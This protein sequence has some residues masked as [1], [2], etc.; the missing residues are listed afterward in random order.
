[1]WTCINGTGWTSW[2]I[3]YLRSGNNRMLNSF[4]S[5]FACAKSVNSQN[6]LNMIEYDWIWLNMIEYDWIWLNMIEYDRI[7]WLNMT[8]YDWMTHV[9]SKT[10]ETFRYFQAVHSWGC[11]WRRPVVTAL[12]RGCHH[13]VFYLTSHSGWHIHRIHSI[14]RIP[15]AV[16]PR[17]L[18]VVI[19]VYV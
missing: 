3:P 6:K 16:E 12:H 2:M 4:Y 8:E 9:E 7:F 17:S 14:I 15:V 18:I 13:S 10:N 5:T 1:M 11:L 19:G